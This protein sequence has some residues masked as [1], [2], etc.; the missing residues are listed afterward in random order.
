M[1]ADNEELQDLLNTSGEKKLKLCEDVKKGVVCQN[2][3]EIAV[4][5]ATDI[6]EILQRGIQQRQTAATLCNKNSSRSHSIFTMKIMIKEYNIEG[7]EV[8]RNGQLNL[9]DLAG[10]EC[11]GR[12]GAKNDRAREAGSINQS[13]LTLGRVITALVD[14]HPHVPYRDSKLTRLLQESLG[15]KAK[16]CIIATFSPAQA[17]VEETLS[18]LDYAHRAK[19]IKNQ[20]TVNQKLTKKVIMKEYFVEIETLRNQLLATREKNGVYLAPED[21]YAMESKIATQEAQLNECEGAL[22]A[23]H[24]EVKNLREQHEVL[25]AEVLSTKQ[26][27]QRVVEALAQAEEAKRLAQSH[28]T[29]VYRVWQST[30]AVVG[31]QQHQESVLVRAGEQLKRQLKAADTDVHALLK[32]VSSLED[33]E[34]TR[35]QR[36][37]AFC[38]DVEQQQESLL[39]RLR[40]WQVESQEMQKSTEEQMQRLFVEAQETQQQLSQFVATQVASMV[41]AQ[42]KQTDAHQKV[43]SQVDEQLL[44]EKVLLVQ[45][46]QHIQHSLDRWMV[47]CTATAQA[48]Q[49]QLQ[50]QMQTMVALVQDMEG[51]KRNM[52]Q[53][54]QQFVEQQSALSASLVTQF[55][56]LVT[57]LQQEMNQ[58]QAS[59]ASAKR[60]QQ[61][62]LA[63]KTA[64]ITTTVQILLSELLAEQ[65]S[66]MNNQA[67]RFE[68]AQSTQQKLLEQGKQQVVQ[69]GL[70]EGMQPL[71]EQF[72][73]QVQQEMD[74]QEARLQ[75]RVQTASQS[76]Q[77]LIEAQQ[78]MQ[79][80]LGQKRKFVT[81]QVQLVQEAQ[82]AAV[83]RVCH[84][85]TQLRESLTADHRVFA[86]QMQSV[87]GSVQAQL[88]T[89]FE[90]KLPEQQQKLSTSFGTFFAHQDGRFT[91]QQSATALAQEQRQSFKQEN[92]ESMSRRSGSTPRKALTVV[93][94]V[95]ARTRPAHVIRADA[96]AQPA[97]AGTSYA[98]IEP[99]MADLFV[100][101]TAGD[102]SN[103]VMDAEDAVVVE[104]QQHA[105]VDAVMDHVVVTPEVVDEEF[106]AEVESRL[107]S[108]VTSRGSSRSNS[109]A[110]APSKL[111]LEC[112]VDENTVC[113][114]MENLP[115][116][117]G[118]STCSSTAATPSNISNKSKLP[119]ARAARSAKA[120][121]ADLG[122]SGHV[123]LRS[124]R[125]N[126][127]FF[128]SDN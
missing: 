81:E 80:M 5:N 111:K 75:E 90:A 106:D 32:K 61:Q 79:T 83:K 22:R 34:Q 35:L 59:Q 56:D 3:E 60:E 1:F 31:E 17:A 15:G 49:A 105:S 103:V 24:E 45:Q 14:H 109:N 99:Q 27:L 98:E 102:L 46:L 124:T 64:N 100:S 68:A 40:D 66:A 110:S 77:Q 52:Q 8:I 65:S 9:V 89:F 95:L 43:L 104:E 122:A 23:R 88:S 50:D 20:P 48:N 21:Y 10:S 71:V 33:S 112:M 53:Q 84:H 67:E 12:S 78:E 96:L 36:T 74:V 2:L 55:E 121:V 92:K 37:E 91:Q 18:T 6:F 38:S 126:S 4:L 29:D 16:T 118:S 47:D 94:P 127:A 117:G 42:S 82:E 115:P 57:R 44:A 108:K 73:Q 72:S 128:N 119:T 30:E 120:G 86:T 28:T 101:V 116:N 113:G 107:S 54:T 70:Q 62:L 19:N 25:S 58:L 85:A 125:G 93:S 97:S 41:D 13:L 69:V 114:D 11:I 51:N 7:E 123:S 76:A 63:Q 39:L 26:E 87:D